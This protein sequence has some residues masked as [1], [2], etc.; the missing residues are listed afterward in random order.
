[1]RIIFTGTNKEEYVKYFLESVKG[2]EVWHITDLNGPEYP[3][4][5]TFRHPRIPN[6]GINLWEA[7][8]RAALGKKGLY[9]DPDIIFKRS[10]ESVWELDF[11]VAI[12]R[13]D[14]RVFDQKGNCLTDL[15]PYN[16]GI[17]LCKNENY[18]PHIVMKMEEMTDDLQN[19]Y[20]NQIAMRQIVDVYKTLILPCSLYNYTPDKY[21]D[22]K[23]DM[24]DKWAIHFK[25]KRKDWIDRKSVV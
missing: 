1:M 14:V 15:M 7:R 18:F 11:D 20:G 12:T 4:C 22:M 2:N 23:A 10:Y 24:S 17:I 13:Q 6:E 3:G 9:C 5:K 25:G 16:G 19:W 21:E 8:A